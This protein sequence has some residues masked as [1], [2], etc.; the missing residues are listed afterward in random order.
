MR[1]WIT[2]FLLITS[3]IVLAQ[4]GAADWWFFGEGA[5]MHFQSGGVVADTNGVMN[6]IEGCATISDDNGDL[7]FYTDGD[8][9][10][11][12]THV[13]MPNGFDLFG[14]ASSTQSAIIVP[15]VVNAGI[16]YIF[17]QGIDIGIGLHYTRVDMSLDGGLGDVDVNEK[18][19][20]LS[21]NTRENVAAVGHGDGTSYWV[22]A[23]MADSDSM[24]AYQ[25]DQNGVNTTPVVSLTGDTLRMFVGG[26][27]SNRDGNLI[28]AC[29]QFHSGD[30][31]VS[32]MRFNN[33]T[34][35]ITQTLNWQPAQGVTAN[36][37]RPYSSEFSADGNV[38]Y[39]SNGYSTGEVI[40]QYDVSAF[41]LVQILNSEFIVID[42][43]VAAG[44]KGG[45]LQIGKDSLIYYSSLNDSFIHV[46]QNP[47]VLGAG[48]DFT[49]NALHLEGRRAF[50]GLP[51]FVSTA[52]SADFRANFG[53]FNDSALFVVDTAGLDSV[54]WE[55]GDPASGEDNTSKFAEVKHFY[56]DTGIYEVTLVVYFNGLSDTLT[57]P[58]Q[59]Y[60]RQTLDLGPDTS[61]CAGNNVVLNAGQPFSTFLWN[62]GSTDSVQTY[63]GDTLV[64]VTVFGVCDTLFDTV[65]ISLDTAFTMMLPEDTVVCDQPLFSIVPS[66]TGTPNYLWTGGNTTGTLTV[67]TTGLYVLGAF[68]VCDTILD[69]IQVTFLPTPFVELPN[70]TINCSSSLVRLTRP[71]NDSINYTWSDSS[72]AL[73]FDVDSTQTV[74]LNGQNACGSSS[75]TINIFQTDDILVN[76]GPDT[77][78]CPDDT[79]RLGATWPNATYIWSTGDTTDSIWTNVIED[80]Y[81]VTVTVD[82]CFSTDRIDIQFTEVACPNIDCR[83]RYDNVFTPNGDGW[84]DL[85]RLR[86]D[87]EIQRYDLRIYSRWGQLVSQSSQI[88]YGWDGFIE[89]E[90]A[91]A[92]VY[93][94]IL[95]YRDQVVV[96]ADREIVQGSFTLI[97]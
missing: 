51:P 59:V 15:D 23:H 86:S 29:D 42:S 33:W 3:H 73:T 50:K 57:Q 84:N 63:T 90:P 64:S 38:L 62:N 72:T 76:I 8:T 87:C 78:L 96:D 97:R 79:I 19:V 55:F 80:V 4:G 56:P 26:L 91:P 92:G 67:D 61:I 53:C 89:G 24:K 35:Q 41:N 40:R 20:L 2:L 10:W 31:S 95:E 14:S 39:V 7:L 34:G 85:F 77:Q 82:S 36:N 47:H 18:N 17:T 5:G 60:P 37:L 74:W 48:C 28:V 9:V 21:R 66:V 68:N 81:T 30:E 22:L 43:A 25:V 71:A 12:A 52:F 44:V 58:F 13:A 88:N 70:D 83:V 11:N 94:F 27:K 6:T 54:L 1:F 75:D 46:I 45:Q 49:W 32:L 93:Y 65:Q 69:T 16:Y